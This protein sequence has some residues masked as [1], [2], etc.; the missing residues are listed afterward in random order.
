[1][2]RVRAPRWHRDFDRAFTEA[3]DMA[4]SS[5]RLSP[6]SRLF[7]EQTSPT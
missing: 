7:G 1:M 3:T 5:L 4:A 6:P 2:A